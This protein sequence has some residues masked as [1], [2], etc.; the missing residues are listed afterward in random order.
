MLVRN[1]EERDGTA[2]G[3]IHVLSWQATYRGVF[4]DDYLDALD[5]DA[6]G[7]MWT[8]RLATAEHRLHERMMVVE[9]DHIVSGFSAI[10]PNQDGL[11]DSVGEVWS[12]YLHPD[13]I[14]RGIGRTLFAAAVDELRTRRYE[15]AVLWVAD[16]NTRARRFYELAGWR[17]DGAIKTEAAFGPPVVE[18]RYRSKLSP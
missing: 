10:G 7:Q 1:A 3:R 4:S 15:Y 13:A 14:G 6:R 17:V 12:I 11:G 18:V 5:P 8:E 16:A 9:V 2:I